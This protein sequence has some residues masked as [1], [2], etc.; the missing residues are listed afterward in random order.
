M[1]RG[2]QRTMLLRDPLSARARAFILNFDPACVLSRTWRIHYDLQHAVFERGFGRFRTNS[3]RQ[4]DLPPK[5][6]V[7]ALGM[8]HAFLAVFVFVLTFAFN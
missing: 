2:A 8:L 1:L 6:S 7:T 5:L 4:R 3:L